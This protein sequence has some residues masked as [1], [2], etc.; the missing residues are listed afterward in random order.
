MVLLS[1]VAAYVG[2]GMAHETSQPAP[3]A[4]A[5]VSPSGSAIESVERRIEYLE[6]R[7]DLVEI[8]LARVPEEPAVVAPAPPARAPADPETT[9]PPVAKKPEAA[10]D[11]SPEAAK[12]S[13]RLHVKQIMAKRLQ[14]VMSL[15]ADASREGESNRSIQATSEAVAL[16]QGHR[17]NGDVLEEE[18]RR[19]MADEWAAG[20]RDIGPLVRDGLEKADIATVRSRLLAIYAET[21]RRLRPHFDDEQWEA[22]ETHAKALRK[23]YEEVLDETERKRLSLK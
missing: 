17:L 5:P 10:R 12:E 13:I 4:P 11:E 7:L 21:D 22:Y 2:A 15:Y 1:G 18:F 19:I 14:Y 20:A 23:A 9:A 16:L 3:A 8:R 6:K